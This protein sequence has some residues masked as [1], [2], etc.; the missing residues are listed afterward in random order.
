MLPVSTTH[1]LVVARA[2]EVQR[3]VERARLTSP[4]TEAPGRLT[5]AL[6]ALSHHLT[7]QVPAP[8][9]ASSAS[10]TAPCCA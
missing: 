6:L 5:S 3:K 4:S 10:S 1:A 8:A 2:Q 9:R 7:R